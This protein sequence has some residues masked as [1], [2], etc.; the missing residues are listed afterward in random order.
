MRS[1]FLLAAALFAVPFA[2]SEAPSVV[3]TLPED[4]LPQLKGLL[5]QAVERSPQTIS[6]AIGV[7]QAEATKMG[8]YAILYPSLSANG[9]YLGSHETETGGGGAS[10]AKGFFYGASVSQPV[11]QWGA[12]KNQAEMGALGLKIAERQYAD[13]YRALATQIREQFME[14]V[15]KKILLRNARFNQKISQEALDAAMAKFSSG[16]IAKSEVDGAT[17]TNEQNKLAADRSQEDYNYSMRVFMR[18]VG[19]DD[20]ND[21][22]VPIMIPHPEYNA[23]VAD[24]ILTG[25][26]GKGIESTFQS[27]VY[28]MTLKQQDLNYA[29]QKVRLLP[30]VSASANYSYSNNTS[31]APHSISQV[32]INS[33]SY[34]IAANWTLFDGFSTRAAKLAALQGKRSVERAKKNYIDSTVDAVTYARHQVDF[35]ARSM[36]FAEVHNALIDAE[37]RR[38]NEDQKLGYG[39]QAII[40]AGTQNL[41]ATEYDMAYARKA[42]LAQWTE[43]ISQANIDP[44]IANISDRYVH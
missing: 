26:V 38:F 24:A 4:Y 10:S 33:E 27:E 28:E 39:S 19:V 42:Y 14:L 32:G 20:F 12:Y 35:A 6:A 15:T 9:D 17:I 44:A 36:G 16:A 23:A 25:F 31:I 13:A 41:Y 18:L 43:F 30:K 37:V 2:R 34:S 29:I 11:Y 1:T 5:Q 8:N 22:S 40:D 3:G 21:D 7:A